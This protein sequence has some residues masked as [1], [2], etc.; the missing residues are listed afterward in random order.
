MV[1]GWDPYENIPMTTKKAVAKIHE[2]AAR[3]EPFLMFFSFPSPHT[4]II[5]GKQFEGLSDAGPYGDYVVETDTVSGELIA[6]LEAAGVSDNTIVIFSADNGSEHLAYERD[7]KFGHWSSKPLRGAKR[8]IYE[9]GHRVPFIVRWPGVVEAGTVSDALISQIDI[10]ATLAGILGIDLPA[11]QAFDSYNQ[12]PVLRGT[13]ATVRESHVHN[14]FAD[15]YAI[16]DGD[17]VLIDSE[18]G[19]TRAREEITAWEARHAY[20]PEDGLPVELYNL[21]LDIEQRNNLAAQHPEKV[22]QLQALLAQIR[23]Q[24]H[25]APHAKQQ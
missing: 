15:H 12:L 23:E 25:S 14:T 5:P 16:R 6:A 17:W 4:P 13:Q 18:M 3:E 20:P 7:E 1:A 24:G 11:D 19:Y 8:D 10:M 22:A 2:Y 21:R 9:G